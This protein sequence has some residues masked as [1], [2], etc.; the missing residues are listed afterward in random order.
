M[1]C[2]LSSK[3]VCWLL[4]NTEIWGCLFVLKKCWL[5]YFLYLPRYS[6]MINKN[7]ARTIEVLHYIR[8]PLIGSYFSGMRHSDPPYVSRSVAWAITISLMRR[9]KTSIARLTTWLCVCAG[10]RDG[11]YGWTN[12]PAQKSAF[13][14]FIAAG[15]LHFC[16]VGF[17]N[18]RLQLCQVWNC[19]VRVHLVSIGNQHKEEISDGC[20]CFHFVASLITLP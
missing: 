12:I 11:W 19:T 10:V 13:A 7:P 9:G 18:K 1:C 15:V 17:V 14:L 5:W 6:W 8:N 2:L 3:L 20:G 16:F 4:L